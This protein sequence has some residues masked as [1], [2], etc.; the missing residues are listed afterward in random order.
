VAEWRKVLRKW[1][2]RCAYCHCRLTRR[3]A[4]AD[5]LIALSRGGTNWIGNIVPACLPCNQRKGFLKRSE[6]LK[7]LSQ[8]RKP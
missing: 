5:H 6:Y 7:R 3:S 4:T 1:Q 8:T 2:Y